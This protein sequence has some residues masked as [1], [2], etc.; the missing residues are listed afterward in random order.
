MRMQCQVQGHSV[1]REDA[2]LSM[3]ARK[4][5]A[6]AMGMAACRGHSQVTTTAAPAVAG[7]VGKGAVLSIWAKGG[8]YLR[9]VSPFVQL[10]RPHS[11]LTDWRNP[12]HPAQHSLLTATLPPLSLSI[13]A[14]NRSLPVPVPA[15]CS[16]LCRRCDPAHPACRPEATC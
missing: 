1:R 13:P 16:T 12:V 6:E 7:V 9:F 3:W 8:G 10:V 5:P 15:L 4:G 2:G 11:S 14:L